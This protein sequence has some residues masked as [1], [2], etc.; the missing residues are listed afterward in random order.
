MS[1]DVSDDLVSLQGIKKVLVHCCCACCAGDII[2]TILAQGLSPTVF[3]YN[4]NIYPIEECIKR[5]T[6]VECF[7][8]KKDVDFIEGKYSPEEWSLAV[9]GLE[10]E[11]EGGKRC[12]K[13]FEV[14]LK[15]TAEYAHE[16]HFRVFTTTLGI[17][18]FKNFDLVT[19]CGKKAAAEYPGLTF[20]DRNWRKQGG[21]Q[22][23]YEIA[24]NENFYMQNYCGCFYSREAAKKRG[25]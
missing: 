9:T 7:A 5:R 3:F 10:D 19:S 22:R 4:P 12:E 2:E 15:K 18:R 23:M 16:N 25:Q 6:D 24:K 17:S 14:R 11:P 1:P 21:S 8:E 13:C 20:W